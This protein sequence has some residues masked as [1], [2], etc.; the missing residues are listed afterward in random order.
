MTLC[1]F[2]SVY[3]FIRVSKTRAKMG[4]AASKSTQKWCV[5]KLLFLIKDLDKLPASLS[6]AELAEK[7]CWKWEFKAILII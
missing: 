1:R 4:A 6:F 2:S 5:K 3:L 7:S